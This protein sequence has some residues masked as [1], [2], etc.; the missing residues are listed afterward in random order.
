[1]AK[2]AELGLKNCQNLKFHT[3][4]KS[5]STTKSQPKTGMVQQGLGQFIEKTASR[6]ETEALFQK[7]ED[8]FSLDCGIVSQHT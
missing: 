8:D 2:M 7:R 6:F 3:F 1:M 5:L 4:E